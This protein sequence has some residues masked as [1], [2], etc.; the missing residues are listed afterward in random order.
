M[1]AGARALGEES[2][3]EIIDLLVKAEAIETTIYYYGITSNAVFGDIEEGDRPY[4]QGALSSEQRHLQLLLNHGATDP[5]QTFWVEPGTFGSVDAFLHTLLDLEH[6][7]ITAYGLA[8]GRLAELGLAQLSMIA[9]R[10]L[11]VE[12]EH[13]VLARD[14]LGF[15][16]PNNLCLE[17]KFFDHVRDVAPALQPFLDGSEGHTEAK[18]L[19]SDAQIAAAVGPFVCH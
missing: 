12:A 9:T 2:R 4:I 10:I 19:P 7:G 14:I 18:Q 5:G 8:A 11:G 13:R 3:Q 17:R 16:L 6:G 15:E 1:L